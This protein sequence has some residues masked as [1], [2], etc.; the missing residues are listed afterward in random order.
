MQL[1]LFTL[2]FEC[3]IADTRLDCEIRLIG[4]N[5]RDYVELTLKQDYQFQYGHP[6]AGRKWSISEDAQKYNSALAVVGPNVLIMFAEIQV[7]SSPV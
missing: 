1:S 3:F 4:T 2:E 7:Q 5:L 6:T